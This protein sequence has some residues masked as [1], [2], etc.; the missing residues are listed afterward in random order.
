MI[1]S[2]ISLSNI[3]LIYSD[4]YILKNI[5]LN[6]NKG[7]CVSIS[8]HN[9]AG[10]TTLF[11]IINGLI[12]PTSGTIKIF[13]SNLDNEIK[14]RIGYIPQINKFEENI[15]ITVNQVIEIGIRQGKAY[16]KN[17]RNKINCLLK[18]LPQNLIYI[19]C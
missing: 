11:K 15:P 10:K 4:K 19:N 17:Y 9:G 18:V 6:I 8:G 16:L 5:N 2:A 1:P 14:K 13:D 12:K 7:D 3:N